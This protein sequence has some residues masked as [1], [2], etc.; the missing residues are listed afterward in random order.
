MNH[1]ILSLIKY[2]EYKRIKWTTSRQKEFTHW[3]MPRLI[4][5]VEPKLTHCPQCSK[6]GMLKLELQDGDNIKCWSCGRIYDPISHPANTQLTRSNSSDFYEILGVAKDAS[7]DDIR[8][9]YYKKSL[10]IHP[11]KTHNLPPQEKE[12]AEDQFKALSRAY[13]CL[14]DPEMRAKYDK[15]GEQGISENMMD[16][17]EYFKQQFGG[18]RFT[19][20]IGEISL[21]SA[22]KSMEKEQTEEEKKMYQLEQEQAMIKRI[23]L[24]THNLLNKLSIYVEDPMNEDT[25]KQLISIE[26]QDLREENYGKELLT[27]IGYIYDVKASQKSSIGIGRFW[28]NIK[29]KANVINDTFGILH[30]FRCS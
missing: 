8:K 25:F 21:G 17:G 7:P 26:A 10:K 16:P 28:S 12:I 27:A 20:I 13:Q 2:W 19:N 3:K 30:S 18:D 11:D 9:Q 22:L 14:S 29:D 5:S 23:D 24:L 1:T 6:S 4:Q 15:H